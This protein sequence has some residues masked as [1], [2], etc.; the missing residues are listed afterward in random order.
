MI[1]FNSDLDNTMIYSYK[2]EIGENKICV[3]LYQNRE[4]SFMTGYSYEMLKNLRNKILF[5][6]TT[7]RTIEQYNRIDLGI[8]VP[9]YALVCNG[10]ILL[11]D[12][13]EDN[14]WYLESGELIA[15]SRKDLEAA[16]SYLETDQYRCFEVRNIRNL[17]IF[18]KS[19]EPEKTVE[20]LKEILNPAFVD[21]FNNGLKVYVIPKKLSKGRAV[22]RLKKRL[23]AEFM[24][25]AGDSV[26]DSSMLQEADI[27]IAPSGLVV[28][29]KGRKKIIQMNEEGVYSDRILEYINHVI[30]SP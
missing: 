27:G 6:P 20:V 16:E 25:A 13:Q 8:G 28:Q 2:H 29:G 22:R 7:T 24:I 23:G 14:E 15:G 19:S 17:F 4:V 18:T 10:G 11:A 1:L 3:E 9:Q 26:F 5:V 12:G 30:C 21:V